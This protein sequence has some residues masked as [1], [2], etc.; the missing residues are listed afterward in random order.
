[1]VFRVLVLT[2]LNEESAQE[3]DDADA[4]KEFHAAR[5]M[6]HSPCAG[7]VTS[8]R[9]GCYSDCR[10]LLDWMLNF[11]DEYFCCRKVCID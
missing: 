9:I 8:G 1:M 2:G 5:S 4:N 10:S 6:V 11:R 3:W 7:V